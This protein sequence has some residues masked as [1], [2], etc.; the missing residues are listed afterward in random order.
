MQRETTR[1]EKLVQ[2]FKITF[3]FEH[4]SPSIYV[5]IQA[6]QMKIFLEEGTMEVV[7]VCSV[8]KT[9]MIVHELLECY[10]V[11]KEEYDEEDP[12]NVQISKTKGEQVVKGIDIESAAYT[13]TIKTWKVKIEMTENPKFAK[14]RDY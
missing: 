13:K 14:R 1:W 12:K 5:E 3:T 6:I 7:L 4:E 8:H 10:N 11:D 9:K 2:R